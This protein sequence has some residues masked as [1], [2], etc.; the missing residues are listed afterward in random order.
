MHLKNFQILREGVS[1]KPQQKRGP[2]S[3]FDL[4]VN[5]SCNRKD[6]Q[7]VD[8]VGSWVE[9]IQHADVRTDL[10]LLARLAVDVR[11][12]ENCIDLS[13]CRERDR[14]RDPSAG[15]FGCFD[16]IG[17]GAIQDALVVAFKANADFLL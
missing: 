13:L 5:A 8:R 14:T 12:S 6:F 15:A 2:L 11:R 16:D 4:D 3:C 10:K 17:Y 1:E 9:D 7:F